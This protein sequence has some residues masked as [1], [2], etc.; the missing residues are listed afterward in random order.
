LVS[1][2]RRR[3]AGRHHDLGWSGRRGRRAGGICRVAVRA[4]GRNIRRRQTTPVHGTCGSGPEQEVYRAAV[5]L[6]P[7]FQSR[8]Q[9]G[10]YRVAKAFLLSANRGGRVQASRRGDWTPR[11]GDGRRTGEGLLSS[12]H[13]STSLGHDWRPCSPSPTWTPGSSTTAGSAGQETGGTNH[14][15]AA[16]R[17]QRAHDSRPRENESLDRLESIPVTSP[18]KCGTEMMCELRLGHTAGG[19]LGVTPGHFC[20]PADLPRTVNLVLQFSNALDSLPLNSCVGPAAG[21]GS[22]RARFGC[23]GPADGMGDVPGLFLSPP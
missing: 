9:A 15:Q 22:L 11:V 7:R 4:T 6:R 12:S 8:E 16:C 21:L 23:R 19:C 5:Q 17:F 1:D 14:S 13:T 2:G 10:S 18:Q 20:A 3:W